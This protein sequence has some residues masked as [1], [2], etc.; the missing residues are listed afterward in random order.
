MPSLDAWAKSVPVWKRNLFISRLFEEATR[1]DKA[2][3]YCEKALLEP[4]VEQLTVQQRQADI[5][6]K[7]ATPN[8]SEKAIQFYQ[9]RVVSLSAGSIRAYLKMSIANVLRRRGVGWLDQA[10]EKATEALKE[11]ESSKPELEIDKDLEYANCLNIYGLSLY[12]Q[13]KYDEAKSYFQRSI[14][15]KKDLGDVNGIGESEN[16]YSLVYTQEGLGFVKAG[17]KDEA[18]RKFKQAISHAK[19]AVESRRRIGNRRGY[20]QNCRNLAWP[21]TELMKIAD[22]QKD[23][24]N[25]F[26]KAKDGY[27]AGI[28]TWKQIMPPPPT[29]I[30]LFSNILVALYI[31]YCRKTDDRGEK[32]KWV[33]EGLNTYEHFIPEPKLK[34][35]AKSDARTPTTKQNLLNIKEL[36]LTSGLSAEAKR[37]EWLITQLGLTV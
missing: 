27:T 9:K 33:E 7:Q 16:A 35:Q 13:R 36:S 23:I 2:I 31:D 25:Y 19:E 1:W 12:S 18:V 30:V 3:D 6:Y 26:L 37:A 21:N 8:A 11:F 10:H 4:L 24:K 34:E 32:A 15:I 17:Q 29:E 22:S 14:N 28:S 5:Y 20:A